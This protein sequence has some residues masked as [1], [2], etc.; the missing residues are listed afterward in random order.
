MGQGFRCRRMPVPGH[1]G[2]V[3]LRNSGLGRSREAARAAPSKRRG[4]EI[5]SEPIA[6]LSARE[7][8]ILID[9][10]ASWGTFVQGAREFPGS[11][12]VTERGSTRIAYAGSRFRAAVYEEG[13]IAE[14]AQGCWQKAQLALSVELRP[15]E[16]RQDQLESGFGSFFRDINERCVGEVLDR[17]QSEIECRVKP[18]FKELMDG[19]A[20]R[21]L[22]ARAAIG[23]CHRKARRKI[24]PSGGNLRI[25]I[26]F[27]ASVESKAVG[28]AEHPTR[29]HPSDR[30]E[31][32]EALILVEPIEGSDGSTH[33]WRQVDVARGWSPEDR[34]RGGANGLRHAFTGTR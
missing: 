21:L 18:H 8:D 15:T 33:L 17:D 10:G 27:F 13:A 4:W 12:A 5:V 6:R 9:A 3:R 19:L 34:L 16:T 23:A 14:R 20:G 25:E 29:P 28:G 7:V 11:V 30:A 26:R 24:D 1:G 2:S 31:Q 22:V 32:A